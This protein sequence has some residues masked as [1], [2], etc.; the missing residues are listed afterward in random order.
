MSE[1]PRFHLDESVTT[2]IANGLGKRGLDCTTTLSSGL[3]GSSDEEQFAFAQSESRVLIT[4]DQDFLRLASQDTDHAGLIYWN[5]KLHFGKVITY[6]DELC[7]TVTAE[8][9]RGQVIYL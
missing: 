2:D 5:T 9:F 6:L 8:G 3:L 7:M 4:A 1:K